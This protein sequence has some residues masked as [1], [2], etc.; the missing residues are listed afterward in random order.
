MKSDPKLKRYY[1]RYNKILFDG[2]LPSNAV[3][4]WK[5]LKGRAGQTGV[6]DGVSIIE[7]DTQYKKER[8]IWRVTLIHEMVHVAVYP[9]EKHG[10]RYLDELKR[11][12]KHDTFLRLL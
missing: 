7:M 5:T 9:Y 2:K 8:T 6:E 12:S 10:R 1:K 4:V 11:V 3:I